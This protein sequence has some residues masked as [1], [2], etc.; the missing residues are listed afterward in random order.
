MWVHDSG[1]LRE[2]GRGRGHARGPQGRG[3]RDEDA[4][5]APAG[6]GA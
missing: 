6:C 2:V 5:G 4:G 1:E 3:D